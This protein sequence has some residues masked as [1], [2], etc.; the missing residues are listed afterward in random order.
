MAVSGKV[1]ELC[2]DQA[3]K[4]CSRC[5]CAY[6]CSADHQKA[7]WKEHRLLCGRDDLVF[8][9]AEIGVSGASIGLWAGPEEAFR[10]IR[11]RLARKL[12]GM[13]G[14]QLDVTS[15]GEHPVADEELAS[16]LAD[17][18]LKAEWLPSA[19][20]E[21]SSAEIADEKESAP[22]VA[23]KGVPAAAVSEDA[24][25]LAS[26]AVPGA[27]VSEDAA[28]LAS[29]AVPGAVVSEDAAA[30]ASALGMAEVP[31]CAAKL[32]G[33]ELR[34]LRLLAEQAACAI[35]Y[36]S[37]GLGWQH[38]TDRRSYREGQHASFT[39]PASVRRSQ[40][41]VESLRN[42]CS[43]LS[44]GTAEEDATVPI[45]TAFVREI[46]ASCT[47]HRATFSGVLAALEGELL[48]PL[49]A[50]NEAGSDMHR[51]YS[52][53]PLPADKIDDAVASITEHV[54]LG[55]FKE[56]RYSNSVGQRQL[57]GLTE[58]QID[59][60]KHATSSVFGD[61][62]VH[63]DEANELGFFWATKIGGPSHG[64]D[65][66]GQ[67]LLP[68]LSNARHKVVLVSDPS[69]PHHPVGR[70][71]FRLLWTHEGN[72]PFLWL[73]TINKDF[74][75]DVDSQYWGWA[76]LEHVVAKAEAMGVVLSCVSQLQRPLAELAQERG[77]AVRVSSDCM[78]LRPSNGVVEASDYLSPKHDWEQLTDEIVGPFTRALYIPR[79]AENAD[80][81]GVES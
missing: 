39:H 81:I 66:E 15:D 46:G 47:D 40:E 52:R 31:S 8:I 3:S 12:G 5:K 10:C 59:L 35:D 28:A 64:F 58:Q 26:K 4:R 75:A 71:H 24:A 19:S 44:D 9:E 72:Y 36:Q 68:L 76:V 79:R 62:R 56:W 51:T 63:E 23:S 1:C 30:L 38:P 6:Y 55:A 70:A 74:R 17:V 65:F 2:A 18:K 43:Q 11:Q 27:V 45:I 60:W 14:C 61:L 69:Y 67:C 73:E 57:E 54:L 49:R 13:D 37:L 48:H 22:G 50:L 33:P 53:M 16:A 32:R 77:A 20:S 29:K 78:V 42:F 41:S 80:A 7:H 34:A 25:A 21:A